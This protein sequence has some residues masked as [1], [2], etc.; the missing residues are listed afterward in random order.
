MQ[1][2]FASKLG[3]IPVL[4]QPI[5]SFTRTMINLKRS[6]LSGGAALAIACIA[7][8]ASTKPAHAL[9]ISEDFTTS[10]GGFTTS[11][12]NGGAFEYNQDEYVGKNLWFTFGSTSPSKATLTSPSYTID[13][14][15]PLT[16]RFSHA[17]RFE[18]DTDAFQVVPSD[19]D[20]PTDAADGG[21]V[22]YKINNGAWT[23][24]PKSAFTETPYNGAIGAYA[25]RPLAEAVGKEVWTGAQSDNS[26]VVFLNSAATFGTFAPGDTVQIRYVGYWDRE[27]AQQYNWRI[28]QFN[29]ADS[30]PT[31]V[32]FAFSPLPGLIFAWG[33][34]A[35]K[36]SSKNR[37]TAKA[38]AT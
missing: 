12:T 21:L 7:S 18:N 20:T 14:A 17:W 4:S 37:Q 23:Q 31:P 35:V 10:D 27:T 25:N 28:Q 24:I 5:Q 38:T 30:T 11:S 9:S 16:L 13:T 26:N 34:R 32:P 3:A 29:L 6:L 33:V 1:I 2:H 22:E 19:P 36:Q 8:I 15:G